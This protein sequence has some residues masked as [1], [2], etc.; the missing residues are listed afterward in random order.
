M[1]IPEARRPLASRS[2]RW[3]AFLS[4]AAVRAGLTA[5]AIS[6]LSLLFAGAGAAGLLWLDSPWNLLACAVGVQLRLLCNL[7]DGMVAIEGGKKS[8]VGVI[9]NEVPDRIADS[10]FI[11]ALGYAVGIPWLGWLGALAAAV[12]AYIRVLGG[13]FGLAQDFRGPLAKQHRMAVLTLGCL[14]G[15]GEFYGSRP[16]PTSWILT[17]TA[18]V[19]AGGALLT[20]VTR[21]HAIARQLKAPDKEKP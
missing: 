5:D 15:I 19:I 4:S 12:T 10:V 20:C 11:V 13:T 7:L 6:I 8:R 18:W 3:A 9:Y 14:L 21:I 2:T 17:G 1:S 16:E